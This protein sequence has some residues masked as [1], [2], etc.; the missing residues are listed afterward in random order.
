VIPT[1]RHLWV[2]A[3]CLL[4]T[5]L[6]APANALVQGVGRKG[7]SALE[8]AGAWRAADQSLQLELN[9]EH[10]EG[11][12]GPEGHLKGKIDGN[13][14]IYRYSERDDAGAGWFQLSDDG[15]HL[16]GQWK[17]DASNEWSPWQL[18]RLNVSGGRASG[19]YAS[20]REAHLIGEVQ[21]D[22]LAF[23]Y[24]ESSGAG[25]GWFQLIDG[26]E[27][28]R[29]EWLAQGSTQPKPWT[30]TRITPES[31]KR[32][33]VI[34]EARWEESLRQ[35]E[36]TFGK[37]LRS[38]FTQTPDVEVRERE[39]HDEADL[40][41]FA[42]EVAFIAEPVVLLVSTHG[43]KRGIHVAGATIGPDAIADS[44]KEASNLELLHLA[45]CSTMA[46]DVPQTILAGL[47]PGTRFPISGYSTEVDWTASALADLTYLT[48][49]LVRG[50]TPE[51]AVRQTHVAAPYSATQPVEGS[52]LTPLGL[53]MLAPERPELGLA[54]Y[55]WR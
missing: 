49:I 6:Q 32:W 52:S 27:R 46:G 22:R 14:L 45:A 35:H 31:G 19:T 44:L 21:G 55:S 23:R 43:T 39:F 11:R 5:A 41:R 54:P 26:G 51:E 50:H 7:V 15:S 38:Y 25:E 20:D 33:L 29:G 1:A 30:G 36:F 3:A 37:M 40:R 13:R 47:S 16:A 2:V 42:H 34:L 9:G 24:T 10:I 18:K 53:T 8:F 17:S 48:F 28:F 4:L 12:Y